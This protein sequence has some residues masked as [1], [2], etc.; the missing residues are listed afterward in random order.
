MVKPKTTIQSRCKEYASKGMV[1]FGES[2]K[3]MRWDI[4]CVRTAREKYIPLVAEKRKEEVK[5]ALQGKDIVVFSDEVE[6]KAGRCIYN[7]LF[8]TLEPSTE[9]QLYLASSSL[10]DAANAA[11]CCKAFLKTLDDYGKSIEEVQAFVAD[12]AR[13]MDKCFRT[14]QSLNEE[15][16]HIQCWPHKLHHCGQTWQFSLPDLNQAIMNTTK[17]FLHA[18]KRKK[19]YLAF[20]S[21]KYPDQPKKWKHF[22]LPVITRWYSWKKSVDYIYEYFDDICEFVNEMYGDENVDSDSD[23]EGDDE[24]EVEHSTHQKRLSKGVKWYLNLSQTVREKIAVFSEFVSIEGK[25]LQTMIQ[26]LQR[27]KSATAHLVFDNLDN[28]ERRLNVISTSSTR[29]VV[30]ALQNLPTF[31]ALT[32]DKK[33][34]YVPVL[35]KATRACRQKM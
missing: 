3:Y 18:R 29:D 12:S 26:V 6:D 13:Y 8:Q 21:K 4:P 24:D 32:D 16:L 2:Q 23:Y 7:I 9:Q 34:S 14:L 27:N 20:L 10:L 1:L 11:N 5:D 17:L 19:Q 25:E 33:K 31:S 15:L 22:P 28:V 35:I 30:I